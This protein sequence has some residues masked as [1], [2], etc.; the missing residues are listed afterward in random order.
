MTTF[1]GRTVPSGRLY[2]EQISGNGSGGCSGPMA[3]RRSC[4][5]SS[6]RPNAFGARSSTA[7]DG[8]RAPIALAGGD[9]AELR[10]ARRR[11]AE[12][13]LVSPHP[14]RRSAATTFQAGLI[15]VADWFDTVVASC[16]VD[17]CDI[18]PQG[19]PPGDGL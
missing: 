8:A 5:P 14:S 19:H 9:E 13:S 17:P 16:D 18:L 12:V 15:H 2:E 11:A 1:I 10:E 7:A 6:R 4:G 3:P